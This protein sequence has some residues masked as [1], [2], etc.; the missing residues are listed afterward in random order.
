MISAT[1]CFLAAAAVAN[2]F[3]Q[4]YQLDYWSISVSSIAIDGGVISQTYAPFLWLILLVQAHP[5]GF[6]SFKLHYRPTKEGKN[7]GTLVKRKLRLQVLKSEFV[8]WAKGN[9][10]LLDKVD[11]GLL[12]IAV[13]FA[14]EMA[15]IVIFSSAQLLHQAKFSL[16]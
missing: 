5:L 15:S 13:Q 4:V 9:P 16:A 7:S 6:W 8:S 1:E 2:V 10:M 3:H 14:T 12:S 11:R